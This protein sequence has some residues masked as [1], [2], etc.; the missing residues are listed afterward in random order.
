MP[1]TKNFNQTEW[2]YESQ[3][4]GGKPV[5]YLQAWLQEDLNSGLPGTNPPTL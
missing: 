1:E 3:L 2:S 5:G 4:V